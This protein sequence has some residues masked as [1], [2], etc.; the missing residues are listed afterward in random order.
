VARLFSFLFMLAL[1][2]THRHALFPGKAVLCP[3]FRL[4]TLDIAGNTFFVLAAH[5]GRLDVSSILSS[6]YPAVTVLLASLILRER[7]TRI[8]ALGIVV[9]LMAL[10][11]ISI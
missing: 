8:Q 7:V 9:A 4:G 1:A 2:L 11:L 5:S 6:L 10:P 3:V